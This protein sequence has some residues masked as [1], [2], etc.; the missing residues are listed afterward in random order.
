MSK[1]QNISTL[2]PEASIDDYYFVPYEGVPEMCTTG[3]VGAIRNG[4]N[5]KINIE[6][7]IDNKY[8]FENRQFSC[9]FYLNQ[10][11]YFESVI[12]MT[13]QYYQEFRK[14][15]NLLPVI[16]HEAGHYHTMHYF[17][18]RL[19]E[20]FASAARKQSIKN[21]EIAPEEKVADLFAVYYTSKEQVITFL[22]ESIRRRRNNVNEPA[23]TN[24]LAVMELC[25]RKRFISG[26]DA[27]DE[28]VRSMIAE[29]CGVSDFYKV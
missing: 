13:S 29:L 8:M 18:N 14:N 19:D 5:P 6:I 12:V 3:F 28:S 24:D 20:S 15:P 25:T 16:W 11:N 23:E 2:L 4:S 7:E 22:N 21:K 26:I 9:C 27:S 17:T 1:Y 10:E